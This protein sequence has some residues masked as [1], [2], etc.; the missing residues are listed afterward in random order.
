MLKSTRQRA[1]QQI[2]QLFAQH[3]AELVG[4]QP[5]LVAHHYTEAGLS[6]QAIPY[7]EQAGHRA[8][9]RSAHAE[10]IAHLSKGL[11]LVKTLPNT[12]ERAEQELRLQFTVGT[13]LIATKGFAALE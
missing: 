13:P 6:A 11:E 2:A 5:E 4:T 8:V 1:H 7:W 12:P 10:A 9:E 3:F